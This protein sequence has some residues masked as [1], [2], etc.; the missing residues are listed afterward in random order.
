MADRK[1]TGKKESTAWRLW[2]GYL[3]ITFL[4]IVIGLPSFV[5]FAW[6]APV[7]AG[8]FA[9]FI[10]LESDQFVEVEE[11]GNVVRMYEDGSKKYFVNIEDGVK[12]HNP[13]PLITKNP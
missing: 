7:Q 2:K 1:E 5:I 3:T 6:F 11:N 10:G 4:V 8:D 9:D 13:D 12:S